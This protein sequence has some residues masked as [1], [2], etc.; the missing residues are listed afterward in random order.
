[1]VVTDKLESDGDFSFWFD[2]NTPLNPADDHSRTRR[3]NWIRND[4]AMAR[5]VRALGDKGELRVAHQW[6]R[7][8]HGVPGSALQSEIANGGAEWHASTA[9]VRASRLAGGRLATQAR[10]G[11]EWRR[12]RFFDPASQIGL[13]AQDTRDETRALD[14]HAGLRWRAPVLQHAALHLS[15]RRERF[16]PRRPAAGPIQYRTLIEAGLEQRTTLAHR[17]TLEAGL[18]LAREDDDFDG[19]V[20]NSYSLRSATPGRRDFTEPRGAFR[21]RMLKGFFLRG[22]I[23]RA[24]RTPSFLELF[25]D[26]GSVAGNTMLAVE[27]GTNKDIGLQWRGAWRGLQADAAV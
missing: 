4:E 18:R 19:V 13:G 22:S 3:N 27:R 16:E 5:A 12:D 20:R 11:Y 25:G 7:R 8:E 17:L 9:E 2:N 14:A 1:V 6:V 23:G 10:L 24:H 15:A 26:T 21:L